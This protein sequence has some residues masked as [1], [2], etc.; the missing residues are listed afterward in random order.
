MDDDNDDD[1]DIVSSSLIVDECKL[2]LRPL[3]Q[4]VVM[5][6]LCDVFDI[7]SEDEE[8]DDSVKAFT[9]NVLS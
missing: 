5:K 4:V 1:D 8:D 6:K 7:G 9:T 3:C 2:V